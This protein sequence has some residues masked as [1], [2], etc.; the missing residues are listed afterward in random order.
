LK[1]LLLLGLHHEEIQLFCSDAH[2][3][4]S[5]R[6][7]DDNLHRSCDDAQQLLSQVIKIQAEKD[8]AKAADLAERLAQRVDGM[9][10]AAKAEVAPKVI[11]EVAVL[12]FDD[13]IAVR[14]YAADAIAVFGRHAESA[15]PSLK[16]AITQFSESKSRLPPSGVSVQFESVSDVAEMETA[17]EMIEEDVRKHGH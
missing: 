4:D 13:R 3:L 8:E 10:D 14:M 9:S 1:L 5:R 6:K 12:L 11:E 15:I 2:I 7:G 17:V 16:L